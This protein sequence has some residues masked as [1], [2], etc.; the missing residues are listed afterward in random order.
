M[1]Y[2]LPPHLRVAVLAA[3][4]T[5]AIVQL[6]R[7]PPGLLRSVTHTGVK[8]IPQHIS[9]IIKSPS[10]INAPVFKRH[11]AAKSHMVN[12]SVAAETSDQSKRS[13][14]DTVYTVCTPLLRRKS[15]DASMFST[16]EDVVK[17]A[18]TTSMRS[19]TADLERFCMA[20]GGGKV[21]VETG[22]EGGG[23]VLSTSQL[24]QP[25]MALTWS[26]V[27]A[28]R[29]EHIFTMCCGNT[30]IGFTWL[31]GA[32]IS[33]PSTIIERLRK[34]MT[35]ETNFCNVPDFLADLTA[36]S[37]LNLRF[38]QGFKQNWN[39][40]QKSAAVHFLLGFNDS[41]LFR[42]VGY[43]A[44][45]EVCSSSYHVCSVSWVQR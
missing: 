36:K 21:H 12:L 2:E 16:E 19:I 33:C 11:V 28:Q 29:A 39:E 40:A 34:K 38:A 13:T 8:T 30:E 27:E 17:D 6:T 44:K 25:P 3:S 9:S 24:V 35:P 31:S 5:P 42:H 18:S 43:H 32:M 20:S 23:V 10:R 1:L 22:W 45:M 41:E 14:E 26:S 15:S 4:S 7:L 37:T